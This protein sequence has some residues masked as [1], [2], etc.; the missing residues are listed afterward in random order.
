[1]EDYSVNHTFPQKIAARLI[2][3]KYCV[4]SSLIQFP[5]RLLRMADEAAATLL[6]LEK[7]HLWKAVVHLYMSIGD[8]LILIAL[9]V[10][11]LY[12]PL[13]AI[14]TIKRISAY[15]DHEIYFNP[16]T[17]YLMH[18]WQG[19]ILS[20]IVGITYALDN[21]LQG[22]RELIT[23]TFSNKRENEKERSLASDHFSNIKFTFLTGINGLWNPRDR[24]LLSIYEIDVNS[25]PL[26]DT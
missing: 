17:V 21:A 19:R 6:T 25:A 13:K 18:S 1:M 24:E 8:P 16:N 23:S 14:E 5:R 10:L 3:T 9:G 4:V 2:S 11:G 12:S 15:M 26:Y 7:K 22:I 20:P